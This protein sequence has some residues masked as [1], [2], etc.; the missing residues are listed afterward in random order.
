MN[1]VELAV[2]DTVGGVNVA[3]AVLVNPDRDM[4]TGSDDGLVTLIANDADWPRLI[5][6]EA[7][8]SDNENEPGVDIDQTNLVDLALSDSSVAFTDNV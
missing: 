7:G 1:R 8:L 6:L 4:P 5:V 3:V 2:V